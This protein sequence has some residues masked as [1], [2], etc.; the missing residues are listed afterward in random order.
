M[1]TDAHAG[2]KTVKL[3]LYTQDQQLQ[4]PVEEQNIYKAFAN[5][6]CN[7]LNWEEVVAAITDEDF[8]AIESNNCSK[9]PGISG[10]ETGALQYNGWKY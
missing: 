10:L 9:A 5:C 8:H 4:L 2:L 7:A 6:T 3:Q 1:G